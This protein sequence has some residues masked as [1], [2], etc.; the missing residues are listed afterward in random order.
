MEKVAFSWFGNEETHDAFVNRKGYCSYLKRCANEARKRKIPVISKIF[1]H[2]EILGEIDS[3]IDE[4]A[5]FS[6]VIICAFMEYSGN[7]KDMENDF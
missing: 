5:Q 1:L 3:V 6:D 4:V 7:A 2:R